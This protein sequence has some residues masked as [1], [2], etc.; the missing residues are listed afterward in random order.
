MAEILRS[1]RCK[2]NVNLVDLVKSFPTS[3]QK[4]AS[5]QPRTSP[6]KFWGKFNSIFIRLLRHD[7]PVTAFRSYAE[8]RIARRARSAPGSSRSRAAGRPALAA[9]ADG[10]SALAIADAAAGRGVRGELRDA[11]FAAA[12]REGSPALVGRRS[13]ETWAK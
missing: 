1:E 3:L 10:Q 13:L 5:I 7:P 8:R 4:S 2:S 12:G 6:S 9:A 11:R